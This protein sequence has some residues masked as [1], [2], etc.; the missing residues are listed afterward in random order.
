MNLIKNLAI[1]FFD[2]L[3]KYL[4]QRRIIRYLKNN[5]KEIN[6][7][8]DIGSHKGTYT[9]LILDNLLVTEK[10]L[11]IEPQKDIYKFI[12]NKYKNNKDIVIFNNAISNREKTLTLF[13][14]KHD[15][16]SSLT[17]IDKKNKYL[18]LKAKLFGGS[19][20]QMI[21]KKNKVKALSLKKLLNK[22]KV[23]RVDLAKIDTEGH[24]LQV[25]QG[26]GDFLKKNLKYL[27]IEFHNS[28]IFV[29][30]DPLEIEKYLKKNNFILKKTFKF[31]FTTWED[32]IYLNKKFK[33]EH[34]R[35]SS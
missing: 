17:N 20:E 35:T 34:S 22:L 9:D 7:F 11:L 18:N 26:A 33:N 21:V 23:K 6:V 32:R 13:I 8:L 24:E 14:N 4:H 27:I 31:P 28:K 15:L 2:I 1:M 5:L 3:D 29:N 16:T 30:Y 19:I 10:L 25:L 12:K